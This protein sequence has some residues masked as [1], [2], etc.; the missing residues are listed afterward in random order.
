LPKCPVIFIDRTFGAF[1][2]AE[3]LRSMGFQVEVH[4]QRFKHSENDDVWIEAVGQKNWRILTQDKDME[5]RHRDAIVR[6][7]AGV[8]I[9]SD[10]KK[11][12]GCEKWISMLRECRTRLIHAAVHAKRPFVARISYEGKLYRIHRLMTHDRSEDIT[13]HTSNHAN[14]VGMSV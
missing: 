6:G 12:E 7:N 14:A 9:L 11:N 1:K 5:T 8:F 2:L 10:T 3:E 4:K 13:L